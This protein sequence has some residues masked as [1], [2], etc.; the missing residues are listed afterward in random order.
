MMA[1]VEQPIAIATLI[2][3]SKLARV[4]MSEGFRS[5]QTICTMRRPQAALIRSCSASGAG[6]EEAPGR[7]RPSASAM[8]VMVLAVPIVMQWPKLRAMP[9]MTSC[10]SSMP[11]PPE[12]TSSQYFQTS[13][14]EPSGSPL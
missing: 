3:F 10:Q 11:M 2:A 4:R 13:E 5:S 12:R 9:P 1:L 14:P 7:Q 8:P 6:I